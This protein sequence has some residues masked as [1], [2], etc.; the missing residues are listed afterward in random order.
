VSGRFVLA[1]S[2][3]IALNLTSP[4]IQKLYVGFPQGVAGWQV[5]IASSI[6]QPQISTTTLTAWVLGRVGEQLPTQGK[7]LV[8][9]GQRK[10]HHIMRPYAIVCTYRL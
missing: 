2:T 8:V 4:E 7:A 9:T 1:Q 10:Q 3:R 5:G 6:R